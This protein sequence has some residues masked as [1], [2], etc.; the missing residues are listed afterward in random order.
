M[1][2]GIILARLPSAL[3]IRL[4]SGHLAGCLM[5]QEVLGRPRLLGILMVR[6]RRHG[7]ITAGTITTITIR[8]TGMGTVVATALTL[9]V[10]HAAA[11]ITLSGTMVRHHH[12]ASIRHLIIAV[13]TY[14]G[15]DTTTAETRRK[16][17]M[18]MI[19]SREIGKDHASIRG[20]PGRC[21]LRFI[22]TAR[23]EWALDG[24]RRPGRGT[25]RV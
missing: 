7:N 12:L 22:G 11:D 17:A 24:L 9:I 18:R 10:V 8:T 16:T 1:V 23:A 14:T 5:D 3:L 20:A 6:L 13:T 25:Y 2:T 4:R 15:L 21:A 19:P